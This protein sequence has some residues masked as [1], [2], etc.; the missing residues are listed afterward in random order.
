MLLPVSRK[1]QVVLPKDPNDCWLFQGT[2]TVHGIGKKC[3]GGKHTTCQRWLW[4]QLFGPVPD[5]LKVGTTCGNGM[6]INPYH[7]IARTHAEATRAGAAAVL[8]PGDL[9]E[10]R[11]VLVDDRTTAMAD[12]LAGRF[13]CHRRTVQDVWRKATW[14]SAGRRSA[15][16]RTKDARRLSQGPKVAHAVPELPVA[17]CG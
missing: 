5:G 15:A 16:R 10:I 2:S 13:G 1:A 3:V 14:A 12:A 9:A 7:L 8:T 17:L 4:E 6:C 11:R